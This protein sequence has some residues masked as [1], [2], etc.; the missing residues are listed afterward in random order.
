[1]EMVTVS[2]PAVKNTY[3][4]VTACKLECVGHVQKRVG[5]RLRNLKKNVKG[6]GGKKGKLTNSIIDRL[7]NYYGIA[8][9]QNVNNLEGMRKSIHA[10]L[11]HVASS[12]TVNGS[13]NGIRI[14]LTV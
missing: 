13:M 9:R 7:Q 6:L 12:S 8:V 14:V 2:F 11:F 10:T 3:P 1:M 5:T 4:S